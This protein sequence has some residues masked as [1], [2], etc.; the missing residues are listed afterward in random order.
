M[1]LNDSWGYQRADDD[2]KSARRVV[3]NLITCAKDTGNYLLN[4]GPKADGTIPQESVTSLTEVGGWLSRNGE[5]IHGSEPC[6]PARSNYASFTRKGSTLY[7]HVYFWPGDYVAIAGLQ[8]QVK[9]ARMLASGHEVKFEQ[10]KFRV[11]FT[12]LPTAAPDHPVTT[13]AIECDQVPTQDNIFVRKERPRRG[14]GI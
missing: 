3:Q 13:I 6:Q 5:S 11:R 1:T 14:V 4:I 10:D 2:W 9:S 7:M 12:G 8:C